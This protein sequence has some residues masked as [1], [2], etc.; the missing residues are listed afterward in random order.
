[1]IITNTSKQ[2]YRRKTGHQPEMCTPAQIGLQNS[3]FF[4]FDEETEKLKHY[5]LDCLKY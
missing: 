2:F 1:M 3:V 4:E 5:L